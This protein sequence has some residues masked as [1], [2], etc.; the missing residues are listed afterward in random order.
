MSKPRA[1]AKPAITTAPLAQIVADPKSGKPAFAVVPYDTWQAMLAAADDRED[2]RAIAAARA[3][4]GVIAPAAIVRRLSNGEPPLR[5]WREF[6][7][8]SQTELA[9]RGGIRQATVSRIERGERTGTA[10]VLARL[11]SA[12]EVDVEDLLPWSA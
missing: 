12:L 10:A 2:E 6:R 7:T 9:A 5:V 4:P 8:L 1:R 11:A 3:S